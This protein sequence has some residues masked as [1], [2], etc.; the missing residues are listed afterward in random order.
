ML[1]IFLLLVAFVWLC[2]RINRS[3]KT[4]SE[5]EDPAP[6]INNRRLNIDPALMDDIRDI[7]AMHG[8]GSLGRQAKV[9]AKSW[10]AKNWGYFIYAI[11]VLGVI[12]SPLWIMILLSH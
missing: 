3:D 2:W 6:P 9:H 5:D 7:L 12:T 1:L 11:L 10:L 8:A 4:A